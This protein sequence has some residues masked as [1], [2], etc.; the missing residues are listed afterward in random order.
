MKFTEYLNENDLNTRSEQKGKNYTERLQMHYLMRKH[1]FEHKEFHD[2]SEYSHPVHGKVKV[3][4]SD[5]SWKHKGNAGIGMDSLRFN[6][7]TLGQA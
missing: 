2:H 5:L 6:F 7:N 3:N 1:G 4:H